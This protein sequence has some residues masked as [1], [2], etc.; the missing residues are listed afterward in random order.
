MGR[1]KQSTRQAT[2]ICPHSAS[3]P[4]RPS[5]PASLQKRHSAEFSHGKTLSIGPGG[6][7]TFRGNAWRKD[8]PL[9]PAQ[10][11]PAKKDPRANVVRALTMYRKAPGSRTDQPHR[12]GAK[13]LKAKALADA[14]ISTS[15]AHRAAVRAGVRAPRPKGL[16]AFPVPVILS[17]KTRRQIW[18]L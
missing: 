18:L 6:G 11:A 3:P 16:F 2:Q 5:P 12:N 17:C 9:A 13:R 14:G 4:R 15:A 10:S 1:A 7:Q 8:V